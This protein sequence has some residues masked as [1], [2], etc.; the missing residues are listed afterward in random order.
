MLVRNYQA[1]KWTKSVKMLSLYPGLSSSQPHCILYFDVA[2]DILG[3]LSPSYFTEHGIYY[4]CFRYV[5]S[6]QVP[7]V[8]QYLHRLICS[9]NIYILMEAPQE[10]VQSLFDSS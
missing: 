8:S 7:K 9:Q 1:V 3:I 6:E 2:C 5:G 4:I 10:Y